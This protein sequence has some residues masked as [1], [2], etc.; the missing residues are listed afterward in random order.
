M[1]P[2]AHVICKTCTDTLVKPNKQCTV[3]DAPIKVEA[4]A[5]PKD[6]KGKGGKKDKDRDQ[7]PDIIELKR[8]G[9]ALFI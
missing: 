1:R 7:G 6:Q 5:L 2:C 3:C 9:M 8:E 4:L